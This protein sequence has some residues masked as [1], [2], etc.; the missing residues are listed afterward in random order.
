M[1][2]SFKSQIREVHGNFKDFLCMCMYA[3][4]VHEIFP[5]GFGFN[6]EQ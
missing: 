4:V 6:A 1:L 3:F 2:R 5:G